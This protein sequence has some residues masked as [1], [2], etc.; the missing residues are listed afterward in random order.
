[1]STAPLISS[2]KIV[3]S[4]TV[5]WVIAIGAIGI[6]YAAIIMIPATS[7]TSFTLSGIVAPAAVASIGLPATT[8]A[9]SIAVS[10][11]S[12]SAIRKLRNYK[13]ETQSDGK[14]ILVNALCGLPGFSGLLFTDSA[15]ALITAHDL[16]IAH[17]VEPLSAFFVGTLATR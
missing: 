7:G 17:R 14:T 15:G 8:A 13:V 5:S 11:G 6:A 10:A 3:T 4:G 1:M 2:L 16:R 12:L 9:I